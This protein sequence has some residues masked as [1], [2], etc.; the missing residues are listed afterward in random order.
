MKKLHEFLEKHSSSYEEYHQHPHRS[1][2]HFALFA[3]IAV[4]VTVTSLTG[5]KSLAL[6]YDQSAFAT[7]TVKVLSLDKTGKNLPSLTTKLL[8]AL[9][10]YQKAS[11]TGKQQAVNILID[12]AQARRNQ[13]LNAVQNEPGNFL[14]SAL[15][16]GLAK[17]FPS[18]V[19]ALFEQETEVSGS[20]EISIAENLDTGYH[21]MFYKLK[22]RGSG[23]EYN[24]YFTKGQPNQF[25]TGD[26]VSVKGVV[27]EN[28]LVLQDATQV[29]QQTVSAQLVSGPTGDQRTIAI[30]VNFTDD[31]SQP[32]TSAQV[33]AA[34]F[35][36]NNSTNAYYQDSSY[37]KTGFS[38]DVTSQWFTLPYSKASLCGSVGTIASSADAAA[39]AAG[40]V[41]SN[42]N[43]K[44]YV[45]PNASC[46][47][48][49]TSTVGGNPSQTWVNGYTTDSRLYNHELGHAIGMMHAS[50]IVCGS[51]SIDVY[52]NCQYGPSSV[53]DIEYGDR[54]D[55]M[56]YWNS[57]Q[58]NTAH[59]IQ[60][61]W[62]PSANIQTLNA[63]SGVYTIYPLETLSGN[64][65]A[66]KFL[67]PDTQENYYLEY[68]QPVGFDS[69]LPLSYV[70]G[71]VIHIWKT[72]SYQTN[73]VDTTPGDGNI[74]NAALSDGHSFEDLINGITITQL[75]HSATSA[76]VQISYG[77]AVCVKGK[78]SAAV[79]PISQTGTAGQS[80]SYV[81]TVT[82]NDSLSCTNTT[83]STSASNLPAGFTFSGGSASIAPGAT[84]NINL[85][86]TSPVG[87][88]DSSNVF[89]AVVSDASDA[90]HG[91]FTS[92]SYIVFTDLLAPTVSI[93]SP[94]D[95][96]VLG[97]SASVT[98]GVTSSDNVA[99]K[100]VEI[101]I[102][103]QIKVT[104]ILLPYSYKWNTKNVAK[105]QH[106]IMA[107]A[108][109]AAGNS[110]S[111][112]IIVTK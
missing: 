99:V 57:N 101:Y 73:L 72:G 34:I 3:L 9:K 58:T 52:S 33:A 109:D 29:S 6:S 4:L 25:S 27:L 44:V 87:F 71:V 66:L 75:S 5:I 61:T 110:S 64:I 45:S 26:Y 21:E 102:D 90:S 55:T 31:T 89:S 41:L 36:A 8:Q 24:L 97:K 38:G 93:T 14:L 106:S 107:K 7:E 50:K 63:S 70:S 49:G 111:A 32:A 47:W 96:S 77:P 23:K 48:A 12:A 98:I 88:A 46:S 69:T 11:G 79:S 37:N 62:L 84:A 39:T 85:S 56:G 105:G 83:F 19:T 104:D 92:A 1:G 43:H 30:L 15:P 22:Q 2:H 40:Y 35:T 51:K 112:S 108:Y 28:N 17:K 76:T 10:Q 78:P 59:K 65:M 82:N 103:G 42:Y 67:K 95:G 80:L 91:N 54:H 13:M 60:E 20:L 18:E 86:V 68:R 16:S 94:V 100:K 74:D 53:T 81:L